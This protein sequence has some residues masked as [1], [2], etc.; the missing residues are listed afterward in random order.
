MQRLDTPGPVVQDYLKAIYRLSHGGGPV[1]TGVLARAL[2]LRPATVTEMLKKLHSQGYVRY[3]PRTGVQ[4]TRRGGEVAKEVLRHHRLLEAFL[5]RELGMT[6]EEAHHE[7]EVL[8]H[9]ISERL[10]E[11]LDEKL[12]FP[13]WDPQGAPIPRRD[14]SLP[15][16]CWSP[17]SQVPPGRQYILRQVRADSPEL[18]QHLYSLGFVPGARIVFCEL[19]PFDG[20]ARLEVDGR[21]VFLGRRALGALRVEVANGSEGENG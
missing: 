10:E 16:I 14:G 3:R 8:E 21:E 19:A 2:G 15:R 6:W 12:G 5:V 7:A 20:P 13:E 11:K 17:L 9:Y 4:L 18:A 1:R